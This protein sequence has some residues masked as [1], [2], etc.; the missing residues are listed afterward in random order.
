MV[1]GKNPISKCRYGVN[2][3]G[4]DMKMVTLPNSKRPLT[5]QLHTAQSHLSTCRYYAER[6][7][8][9]MLSHT[10]KKYKC[11]D[12]ETID[13]WDRPTPGERELVEKLYI[14]VIRAKIKIDLIKN[15]IAMLKLTQKNGCTF[16]SDEGDFF[17]CD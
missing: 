15:E 16:G 6:S 7:C 17:D 3:G 5:D 12:G 4:D 8:G 10:T 1:D 11:F 9:K 14:N 2:C 13:A